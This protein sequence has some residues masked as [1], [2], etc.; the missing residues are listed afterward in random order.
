ME[1]VFRTLSLCAYAIGL[2][3]AGA[4]SLLPQFHVHGGAGADHVAHIFGYAAVSL[5]AVLAFTTRLGR[6]AALLGTLF[7]G[8]IFEC[9][10]FA[11]PGREAGLDDIL[12]NALGLAL[13]AGF[14]LLLSSAA[15]LLPRPGQR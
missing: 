5:S 6:A 1:T 15:R 14:G 4:L 8:V 11:L 2:V 9:L 12:A 10:Q 13:G 7:A 3:L